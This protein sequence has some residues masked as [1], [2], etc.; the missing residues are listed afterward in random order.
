M[1]ASMELSRSFYSNP[2]KY[3][4]F[5][6]RW[7]LVFGTGIVFAAVFG[8]LKAGRFPAYDDL[9]MVT[10]LP[11]VV[12]GFVAVAAYIGC[13]VLPVKLGEAGIKTSNM[14]GLQVFV[15]WDA[16]SSA[17]V[18]EVAGIP[19][20]FLGVEGRL[21]PVTVPLWLRDIDGFIAA[22]CEYAAPS[23]PLTQI[24]SP[25]AQ[26]GSQQDAAR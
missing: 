21:Q 23:N 4:L 19:Y 15:P 22:V 1:K 10:A 20:I 17:G 14:F 18:E 2:I 24:V 25:E 16:I 13:S 9:A 7:I 5:Y 12:Y 26:P 3:I 6:R 8:Q 11:F